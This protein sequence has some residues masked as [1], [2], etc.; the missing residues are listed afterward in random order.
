MKD[1]KPCEDCDG[2]GRDPVAAEALEQ[3]GRVTCL[4]CGGTGWRAVVT[5]AIP[6]K[7]A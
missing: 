5:D 1:R 6:S 4:R 3:S 7:G 2:T